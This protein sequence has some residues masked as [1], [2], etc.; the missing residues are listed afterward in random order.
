MSITGKTKIIADA[1]F[2]EI[3][4]D[5]EIKDLRKME[6][7]GGYDLAFVGFPIIGY[8]APEEVRDFLAKHGTGKKIALFV[9]HAAPEH[10]QDLPPWLKNCREAAA[11]AEVLGMFNC[12]GEIAQFVVDE[13]LKHHDPKVRGWGEHAHMTKGQPDAERVERARV[14]AK[15]IMDQF[16]G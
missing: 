8:N 11:S 1:I 16:M 12:Q 4:G 14:F 7:L 15:E 5:K 10:S 9:T 13:L 2:G 3:Q 6:N